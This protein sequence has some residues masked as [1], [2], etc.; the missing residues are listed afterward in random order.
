MSFSKEYGQLPNIRAV[1]FFIAAAEWLTAKQYTNP[2]RITNKGAS[3]GGL[4]VGALYHPAP[5]F[6]RT[7][8]PL[9]LIQEYLKCK[10]ILQSNLFY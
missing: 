1:R 8:N 10:G 6:V 4:L 9:K 2:K 3:N 5:G 7:I